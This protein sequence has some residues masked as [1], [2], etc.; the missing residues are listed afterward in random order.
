MILQ[1]N[2]SGGERARRGGKLADGLINSAL[3]F[4]ARKSVLPLSPTSGN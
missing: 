1:G 4:V 3:S 2:A